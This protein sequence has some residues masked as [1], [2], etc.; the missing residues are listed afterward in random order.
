M[1][2]QKVILT[3][4]SR[5]VC[6]LLLMFSI[7]CVGAEPKNCGAEY[8]EM[9]V[10]DY[11]FMREIAQVIK[12][13][14][15]NITCQD[16]K[17]EAHQ[18]GIYDFIVKQ[19]NEDCKRY[20]SDSIC[21]QR[22]GSYIISVTYRHWLLSLDNLQNEK[23]FR[24]ETV[25]FNTSQTLLEYFIGCKIKKTP[26]YFSFQYL[27][28]HFFWDFEVQNGKLINAYYY[29]EK[30]ECDDYEVYDLLRDKFIKYS[31]YSRLHIE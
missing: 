14:N 30:D 28:F 24:V 27:G 19:A 20:D 8:P 12:N 25:L 26:I 29:Y 13:T 6:V 17:I 10:L 3:I 16:E 21:F 7:Y 11:P 23:I 5:T 15:L 22:N 4:P 9:L 18:D 1:Y 31:I 2:L